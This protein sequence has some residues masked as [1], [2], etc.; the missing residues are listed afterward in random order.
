MICPYCKQGEITKAKLKTNNSI[1]FI[2][3]ECDTVWKEDEKISNITGK[4]FE[5]FAEEQK[6]KPVWAELELL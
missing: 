1:I 2:C 3:E 4:G 6:I 5:F